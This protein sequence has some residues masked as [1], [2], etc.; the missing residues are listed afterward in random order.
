MSKKISLNSKLTKQP[1]YNQINLNFRY[2]PKA[3]PE[4]F[5]FPI[6][7]FLLRLYLLEILIKMLY[8]LSFIID[9][10]EAQKREEEEK[11]Q[12]EEDAK[13]KIEKEEAE[14]KAREEAEK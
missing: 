9:F 12:R 1:F 2:N 13:Q 7:H 8:L 6:G 4:V 5:D 10:Q 14:R 11:L 3:K